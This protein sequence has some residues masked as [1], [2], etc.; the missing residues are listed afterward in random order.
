M[1]TFNQINETNPKSL[2][3][4]DSLNL[5]FRWAHQGATDFCEDYMRT[6]LSLKKSYKCDKMIIAADMGSSSFR[7]ALDP[8][9]KANR[10]KKYEDYDEEFED[11]E[12]VFN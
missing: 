7:K 6:V 11:D 9:Y 1:K 10:K 8:E 3:I 4:I 2:M 5:G 12:N